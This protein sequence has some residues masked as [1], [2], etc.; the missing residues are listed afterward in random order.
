MACRRAVRSPRR[1]RV[2]V[3][4][5]VRR[6][7]LAGGGTGGHFYP[8]L[9]VAE[10]LRSR[11]PGIELTYIGT[12]KGA[13]VGLAAQHGL[14]YTSVAAGQVRGKSPLRIASSLGRIA[15][16]SFT[17]LSR[18]GGVDVVFATGGYASVP[19]ISAAWARRVPSVVFLP[20]VEPGWAVRST[21]GM[22]KRVAV[23]NDAALSALPRSKSLVTG[24]P[25]R[26]RFFDIDR[27]TARRDLGLPADDK[28]ILISGATLGS[29]AINQAVFSVLEDLL[30]MAHVIHSTGADHLADA[31]A[32]G[33]DLPGPLA[34]RYHPHA[35]IDDMAAAMHAADLGL[36]RSGA[37][38][39]GEVP[40][41]GL[42]SVFVPGR[43]AGGHQRANAE[44]LARAGAGVVL[45]AP[46]PRRILTLVGGLLADDE[47]RAGIAAAAKALARP[48][49]AQ[50]LAD[51]VMESAR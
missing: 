40:A 51:I 3:E 32:R 27:T 16:G 10:V 50:E 22:A 45:D 11:D 25:V 4:R 38:V 44:A 37:S 1:G 47:K 8:A 36:M 35:F 28:I 6:V 41:A 31:E 20:D 7:V 2:A 12:S 13:E 5:T 43:F 9:A 14:A 26:S 21:I 23:S 30:R 39:L 46:E 34:E 48:D 17:A 15:L 19:V 49:A 29:L 18:L 42:P 33:C 24:Y